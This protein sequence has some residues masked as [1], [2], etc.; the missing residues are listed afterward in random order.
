MFQ[1]SF[2]KNKN[3]IA[4]K[5]KD[6]KITYLE[7]LEFI[8]RFKDLFDKN[9]LS[10]IICENKLGSII[11]YISLLNNNSPVCLIDNKISDYDLLKLVSNFYPKYLICNNKK[12]FEFLNLNMDKIFSIYDFA[13][14]KNRNK[15]KF[16]ISKKNLLLLSTSGSLNEPKF[17]KLSK[18]NLETNT[19][20]IIKY[21][22]IGSRDSTITTMPMHYSYGLS[23]I[24]SH[25]YAGGKIILTEEGLFSKKFYEIFKKEKLTNFNGVPFIYEILIKIGLEKII[26]KNLRFLTQA[27]GSLSKGK[28]TEIYEVLKNKNISFYTMYGQT[29]ASP[30]ISYLKIN[31]NQIKKDN[32][33]IGKSI[34]G[35]KIYLSKRKEII[36][37]GPNVFGGYSSS[38]KD[39]KNYKKVN[40]LYTKDIGIKNENGEIIITGRLNRSIKIFGHRLNL[41]YLEKK[42]EYL[43]NCNSAVILREKKVIIFSEKKIEIS[44]LTNLNINIFQNI[45]L[46]KIPLNKNM[47]KNY[48]LLQS[49]KT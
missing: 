32:L 8:N 14:Y 5:E 40:K 1:K 43:F 27:G 47:K 12:E 30:R 10:F 44:R 23:V 11:S 7:L 45:I 29:E 20:G 18:T 41:D 38:Y 17:V 49:F 26:S 42:I 21:L 22:G 28:I 36:F 34:S 9:S 4:L 2:L 25:L 39:L 48:F 6:T 31:K 35:G 24:N 16:F 13:V 19:K 33:S 15:K 46:S 37:E 3:K